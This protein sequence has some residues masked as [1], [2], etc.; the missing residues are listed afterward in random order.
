M[1]QPGVP[2]HD[3][4]PFNRPAPAPRVRVIQLFPHGGPSLGGTR[5]IVTG[6]AFADVGDLRCR[7]GVQTVPAILLGEDGT[8][9][10]CTTPA[11]ERP[12]C[13]AVGN[14]LVGAVKARG[15]D[16]MAD[17]AGAQCFLAPAGRSR[18][19]RVRVRTS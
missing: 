6:T 14:W 4:S 1:G 16:G 9:L 2:V 7:F 18:A 3:A 19:A 17:A 11:C 8:A 12:S 10:E 13:V 5:V 15:V